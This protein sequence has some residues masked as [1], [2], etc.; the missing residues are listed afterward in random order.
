MHVVLV[1]R[2]AVDDD[3]ALPVGAEGRRGIDI[4]DAGYA[5]GGWRFGQACLLALG[6]LCLWALVPQKRR[7]G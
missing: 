1:E 4:I 2:V 7:P 6:V 3:R 5:R